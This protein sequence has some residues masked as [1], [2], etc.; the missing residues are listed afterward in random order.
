RRRRAVGFNADH[1]RQV[2]EIVFNVGRPWFMESNRDVLALDRVKLD[3]DDPLD[4]VEVKEEPDNQ[5]TH[6]ESDAE[7]R[8]HCLSGS[9]L[10]IAQND[11]DGGGDEAMKTETL[12]EAGTEPSRRFRTHCFGRRESNCASDGG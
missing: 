6:R 7:D 1:T 12:N 2:S 4:S 5:Q 10:E 8:H 11:P 9:S 3:L